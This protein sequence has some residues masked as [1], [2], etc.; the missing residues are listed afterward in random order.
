MA[1]APAA[2]TRIVV[3]VDGSIPSRAALEWALT[4][5]ERSGA[6][7]EAVTVWQWPTTYGWPAP[8]PEGFDPAEDAGR[9]LEEILG[10]VRGDHPSVTLEPRVA[11]GH[12]AELLTQASEGA[13]LLVVGSRG[14]GA[15]AG[16]LLGSVSEHCVAH[17][18]CPVVVVRERST[19]TA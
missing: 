2:A 12:P 17:A 6:V 1:N 10:E 11:E 3:G 15:F 9:V 8:V 13:E 16:M 5:A 18:H 19:P 7:V 4:Q 14:H